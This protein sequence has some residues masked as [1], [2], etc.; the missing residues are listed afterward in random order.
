MLA[1]K[2]QKQLH[3]LRVSEN[4]QL[5][6]ELHIIRDEGHP[7]ETWFGDRH[8]QEI[9]ILLR[10]PIKV[11][12]VS[13]YEQ[14]KRRR[15]DKTEKADPKKQKEKED[16][17]ILTG[18]SVKIGYYFT[19]SNIHYRL[20][21]LP[22]EIGSPVW[23][24]DGSRYGGGGFSYAR[25]F[26]RKLVVFVC[27]HQAGSA[28][29]VTS[30]L[31][32]S[33]GNTPQS[34]SLGISS[35][36][37]Q[38][39][40]EE[41]DVF[42]CTDSAVRKH[43]KLKRIV[44]GMKNAGTS[45]AA[46]Q[47]AQLEGE[48]FFH[49]PLQLEGT[50]P[51]PELQGSQSESG[52]ST[53]QMKSAVSVGSSSDGCSTLPKN[54]GE[55]RSA[56]DSWDDLDV[57]VCKRANVRRQCNTTSTR[58]LEQST[59]QRDPTLKNDTESVQS[60]ESSKVGDN[61]QRS[62]T[63]K[64]F[65]RTSSDKIN[66]NGGDCTP[67]EEVQVTLTQTNG[68]TVCGKKERD[69]SADNKMLPPDALGDMTNTRSAV[70][71]VCRAS[72]RLKQRGRVRSKLS[73]KK[74]TKSDQQSTESVK[75]NPILGESED[76]GVEQTS[77]CVYKTAAESA[78][79]EAVPAAEI[80]MDAGLPPEAI[81]GVVNCSV[82]LSDCQ[83][84]QSRSA[85][86]GHKEFASPEVGTRTSS[87]QAQG[88]CDDLSMKRDSLLPRGTPAAISSSSSDDDLVAVSFLQDSVPNGRVPHGVEHMTA[89]V[90]HSKAV[91]GSLKEDQT[92]HSMTSG[93]S[94]ASDRQ[95]MCVV[96]EPEFAHTRALRTL[97]KRFKQSKLALSH[98]KVQDALPTSSAGGWS[99]QTLQSVNTT[100]LRANAENKKT[101]KMDQGEL[102]LVST[103]K[104]TTPQKQNEILSENCSEGSTHNDTDGMK[105]Q[106]MC[107]RGTKRK[108][109]DI[110]GI[111]ADLEQKESGR[112][113]KCQKQTEDEM[114][115]YIPGDDSSDGEEID[116]G[117][118]EDGVKKDQ[119][120]STGGKESPKKGN[121]S[122][123][124]DDVIDL[125]QGGDHADSG[126]W[127]ETMFGD[128]RYV[129]ELT[130]DDIASLTLRN[131]LYLRRIFTGKISCERHQLYK[132][133]PS[134]RM[135]LKHQVR[136][137]PF[138]DEQMDAVM[139]EL[140][141]IY[142]KRHFKYMDYI[143]KVLLPEA[144]AKIYM[145]VHS[146]SHAQAEQVIQGIQE[147]QPRC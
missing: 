142:C 124:E 49:G 109:R 91:P 106:D 18:Q 65:R 141:K 108:K 121:G 112:S 6:T 25:L 81:K 45:S 67:S 32:K 99:Q 40:A 138:R 87:K 136:L 83:G 82:R 46:N 12:V 101:Q 134:D 104:S 68:Q 71:G 89:P 30:Q 86:N 102:D 114:P 126:S 36:F 143:S 63:P 16:S 31:R 117:V 145:D 39:N 48:E 103:N 88:I 8:L 75:R 95:E 24:E 29:A 125:S 97:P 120:S 64:R 54:T 66:S 59:Q 42:Q 96:D 3:F 69:D 80:G 23:R 133:K 20:C 41:H 147:E 10:D 22:S 113:S 90:L 78:R 94:H 4:C 27:N 76:S 115:F 34:K 56:D 98:R 55:V 52:P 77:H 84:L 105:T 116:T 144:M 131:K 123:P 37:A 129:R 47:R 93:R 85:G 50:H 79:R 51:H 128:K 28:G 2:H 100:T 127:F 1:P 73:L 61:R 33:M 57:R 9:V 111:C 14:L 11:K 17:T 60:M 53:V 13:Y 38:K 43:S 139:G 5:L 107:L 118:D 62:R 35:Y 119:G 44:S 70:I 26:P 7:D 132:K 146:V 110:D 140:V 72:P 135:A 137:G 19:N 21:V 122:N 74:Q 92:S 58:K 130:E 15:R